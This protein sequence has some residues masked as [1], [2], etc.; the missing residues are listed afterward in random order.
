MDERGTTAKKVLADV[1]TA[2]DDD[3]HFRDGKILRSM[4]TD[5]LRIAR[6]AYAMF[7]EDVAARAGDYLRRRRTLSRLG[8]PVSPWVW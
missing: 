5:P 1:R 4:C 2:H 3:L 6:R 7:L 8:T